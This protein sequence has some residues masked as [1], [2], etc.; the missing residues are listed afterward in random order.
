M[1]FQ[2]P[3]QLLEEEEEDLEEVEVEERV[4]GEMGPE[5]SEGEEEEMGPEAMQML[6]E[7]G[8]SKSIQQESGFF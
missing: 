6:M 1:S 4:E 7:P 5:V 8:K 2:E 3:P